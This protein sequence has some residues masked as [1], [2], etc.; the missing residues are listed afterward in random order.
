MLMFNWLETITSVLNSTC[1]PSCFISLL[2]FLSG[3]TIYILIKSVQ[4][5][6]LSVIFRLLHPRLLL[7][8]AVIIAIISRLVRPSG[9]E[10]RGGESNAP[11]WKKESEFTQRRGGEIKDDFY[12]SLSGGEFITWQRSR[13][14]RCQPRIMTCLTDRETHTHTQTHNVN[15]HITPQTHSRLC[16]YTH[17][18]HTLTSCI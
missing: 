18:T 8:I 9:R 16:H 5:L 4:S 7:S 1:A 13:A 14:E 17:N 3:I 15:K 12:F 10:R 6:R 2:C 11:G